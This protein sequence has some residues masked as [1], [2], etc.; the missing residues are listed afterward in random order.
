MDKEIN[1]FFYRGLHNINPN[2][3]ELD[4]EILLVILAVWLYF[5]WADMYI[6]NLDERDLKRPYKYS[7]F[8]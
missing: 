7:K 4:M 6:D 1:W 2:G 5:K 3:R 8:R